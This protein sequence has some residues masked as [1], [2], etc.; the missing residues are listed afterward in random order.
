M[1]VPRPETELVVERALALLGPAGGR[2]RRPRH[3]LRRDRAGAGQRAPAL[4]HRRHRPLGAALEVARA[5]ARALGLGNV[6]FLPGDWFAPLAGRRFDLIASNPP[7]VAAGD[8]A[9]R[10]PALR[11]EPP[12]ALA[13]GPTGLEALAT[14][15]RRRRTRT[16]IPA[17]G[18]CSNTAPARPRHVAELLVA[19]GF[20]HVR[21]HPDL[22]GLE[23]VTEAQ[24]ALTGA[25][26]APFTSFS[27]ITHGTFRNHARRLHG[28]LFEK[29]APLTVANF[30]AS[31]STTAS[32][33]ARSSIASC[34]AS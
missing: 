15:R 22:A 26:A 23:R 6:D 29:E 8:P 27:R 1:L 17:A 32:S 20:R 25:Q 2:R 14:D 10:D 9:L 21:C 34:R 33:T 4:A 5:N 30:L 31:T 7:Y 11:H 12:A 28:E 24:L 3:R 19:Q 16:C 13:S 18:W